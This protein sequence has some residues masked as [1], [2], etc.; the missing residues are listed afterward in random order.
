MNA[1]GRCSG[2][3]LMLAL[4]T[5]CAP[6]SAP[7][8][9]ATAVDPGVVAAGREIFLNNGCANCHGDDGSGRG[10]IAVAFETPPRDYRN[11]GEYR[12][13]TDAE[14]IAATIARGIP[15]PGSSMPAFRHLSAA[16]RAALAQYIV[17]LQHR[18]AADVELT[19]A[20]VAETVPGSDVAAGYFTLTNRGAA[21]A[22]TSVEA[23][24]GVASLHR[25]VVDGELMR[26][27]AIAE[28]ALDAGAEISLQP[29][30][31]HLMLEG[32][33]TRLRAGEEIELTLFLK[34][35]RA[36]RA[37]VPVRRREGAR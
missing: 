27:E 20:W 24:A 12:F 18:D 25:Q 28:L 29:G 31:L 10:A 8:G 30:G 9:G 32:I 21:D 5:A 13:G 1:P 26:M 34:S 7:A 14:T 36:V 3:A 22:V 16:N 19:D 23:S 6:G 15:N 11:P 4:M 35:R 17:S 33:E 37:T 2:V